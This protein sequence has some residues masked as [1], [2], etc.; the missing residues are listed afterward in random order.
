MRKRDY[1]AEYAARVER[2]QRKGF[3]SYGQQ[4]KVYA[5]FNRAADIMADRLSDPQYFAEYFDAD[6]FDDLDDSIFW[7]AFRNY[8][9]KGTST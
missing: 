3:S 7:E 9:G 4:R 6:T 1:K 2:A 8:Y 5:R